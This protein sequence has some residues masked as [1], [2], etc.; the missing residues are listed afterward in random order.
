MRLKYPFNSFTYMN[1]FQKEKDTAEKYSFSNTYQTR[2][3]LIVI[4]GL[5]ISTF[6][7]NQIIMAIMY[8]LSR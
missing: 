8:L 6:F 2:I 1:R 5:C 3:F 7:F 4:F